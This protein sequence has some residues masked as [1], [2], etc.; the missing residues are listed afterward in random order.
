MVKHRIKSRSS[1]WGSV[2]IVLA[3]MALMCG[4]AVWACAG[5]PMPGK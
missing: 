1:D 5:A 2:V 4:F 3:A